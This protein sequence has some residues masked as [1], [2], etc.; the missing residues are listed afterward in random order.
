MIH[1]RNMTSLNKQKE[2]FHSGMKTENNPIF[3]IN[4][5]SFVIIVYYLRIIGLAYM[6]NLL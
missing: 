6:H 5:N 4:L 2:F 1:G 3:L